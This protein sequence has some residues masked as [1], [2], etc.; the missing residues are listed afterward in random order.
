MGM[1]LRLAF[2]RWMPANVPFV[3]SRIFLIIFLQSLLPY[4][5]RI[6]IRL[7]ISP[8]CC[9][10]NLPNSWSLNPVNWSIPHWLFL[11]RCTSISGWISR[12]AAIVFVRTQGGFGQRLWLFSLCESGVL[13]PS[14]AAQICP[15]Q[16]P[17]LD[18]E[19]GL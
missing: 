19:R 6:K 15:A 17:V 7:Q 13:G 8:S 18:S 4:M 5:R 11:H 3:F 1:S 10:G 16:K 14:Q 12:S 2:G 9:S